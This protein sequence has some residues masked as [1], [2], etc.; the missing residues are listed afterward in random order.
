M[1]QSVAVSP[2]VPCEG[3]PIQRRVRLPSDLREPASIMVEIAR[4]PGPD[5]RWHRFVEQHPAATVAHLGAWGPVIAG[6]YGHEVIYL[7]AEEGGEP[8][9][10][11][12]LVLIQSRLFGRRLVSMPFLDYG[13]VLAEPGSAAESA[14][15]RTVL[16]LARE[17][18]VQSV[19]LR[20]F[21]VT[22]LG[23]PTADDRVSM[24]LPLTSEGAVWRAL[25]SERR[26]RVRKGQ[27]C[28][29][30]STW[31]GA[32]L[33]GEFYRVFTAN[34]RD[35]GSPVHSPRF[36]ALMLEALGD[37]ARVLVIRDGRRRAVGAAVC[38]FFRDTI[39]V[40]W[41]S[42]LREAFA[43]CANFT[44]YWEV[45]RLGCAEGYQVLDFGRS[46]R[47]AGTFEFKRQWGAT[48]RTLPWIFM[49]IVSG[50]P[51]PV[52][53]D[54]GRFRPLVEAWKRLPLP[55]ANRLGPWIRGQVP[56]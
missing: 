53:R 6:T 14:L 54:A 24:L 35:L 34:M 4:L 49:D 8:V 16:E 52:D 23:E 42:S 20:Q 55:L 47:G 11:L 45:I 46:F 21:Y 1:G 43:L 38:L 44:L 31:G 17:R 10:A 3:G 12:P 56:N 22:G 5:E 48:P 25:S 28:G 40:P 50:A 36:F 13:G 32:E 15:T 19:G 2:A 26:N 37:V 30:I 51:P 9:G 18:G 41:V 33:L 27:K 39:M 7:L 29:L